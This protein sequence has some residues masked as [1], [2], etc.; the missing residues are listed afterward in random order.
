[1]DELDKKILELL[2]AN[3]RMTVKEISAKVS[4]SSPAVSERIRRLEKSGIISGYTVVL[5]P[6]RTRGYIRAI[7]SIYV[8]PAERATMQTLLMQEEAVEE[9]YQVTGT[10]S[11]MIRV[12]CKDINSLDMLIS[13][14][15][16]LGQTS[17]QI[18]LSTQRGPATVF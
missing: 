1:M 10:Q 13:R 5:N 7:I 3:A 8:R 17:T 11:H 6:E 4:L 9:C 12:R 15:Q 16:K 2:A 18:I 14:L